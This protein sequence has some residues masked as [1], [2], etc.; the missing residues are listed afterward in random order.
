MN[1]VSS[2][3][4]RPAVRVVSAALIGAS[5]AAIPLLFDDTASLSP[6]CSI[7]AGPG[8]ALSLLISHAP[9]L[10]RVAAQA[11][12]QPS[13]DFLCSLVYYSLVTYHCLKLVRPGRPTKSAFARELISDR[14]ALL[15]IVVCGLGLV[16]L[17]A[18]PLLPGKGVE[19]QFAQDAV[20][21]IA[22]QTLESG[23]ILLIAVA[24][25]ICVGRR[26][27]RVGTQN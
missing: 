25:A 11:S 13:L 6:V 7:L 19:R 3:S 4:R 16:A 2:P 12:T 21:G 26:R 10:W 22:V 9:I 20:T 15:G 23:T 1:M 5:I 24:A 14:L 8:Q 17:G 27:S 18:G